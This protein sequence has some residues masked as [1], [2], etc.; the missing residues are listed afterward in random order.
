MSTFTWGCENAVNAAGCC[1]CAPGAAQLPLFQ[2]NTIG[3]CLSK[4]RAGQKKCHCISCV[5]LLL[6][7]LTGLTK[8]LLPGNVYEGTYG[9]SPF[10]MMEKSWARGFLCCSTSTR[11]PPLQGKMHRH[12]AGVGR[13]SPNFSQ[14]FLWGITPGWTSWSLPP[15][16]VTLDWW[17]FCVSP[18][19]SQLRS[20]GRPFP[21]SWVS[22][23]PDWAPT[24]CLLLGQSWFEKPGVC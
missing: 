18:F 20:P 2:R 22:E 9:K 1:P 13:S 15:L 4:C 14:K 21:S 5:F 17:T 7:S 16:C 3:H 10:F 6:W 8:R 24:E 11:N 12:I 19:L 23:I